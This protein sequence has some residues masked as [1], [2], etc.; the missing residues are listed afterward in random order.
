MD[1]NDIMRIAGNAYV[2]AFTDIF[3]DYDKKEPKYDES[4]DTL[5]KFIVIELYETYDPDAPTEAQLM[6][7]ANAMIVAYQDVREV[8]NALTDKYEQ[9]NDD[10]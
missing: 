5:A 10:E 6:T 4:G 8:A 9:N 2:D 1:I 3:W 7:A